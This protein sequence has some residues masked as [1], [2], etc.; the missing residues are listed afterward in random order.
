MK[1]T[2]WLKHREKSS[3]FPSDETTDF[4]LEAQGKSE[5]ESSLALQLITPTVFYLWWCRLVDVI[6]AISSVWSTDKYWSQMVCIMAWVISLLFVYIHS[7]SLYPTPP[8]ELKFLSLCL[9][10][11]RIDFHLLSS[12]SLKRIRIAPAA[13]QH[14]DETCHLIQCLQCHRCFT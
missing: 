10:R 2:K 11:D 9:Y 14:T 7:P 8:K 13:A 1:N 5:M 12:L 3:K 6:F 4:P